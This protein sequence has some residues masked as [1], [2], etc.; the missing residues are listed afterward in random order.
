MAQQ[1]L[2][3]RTP[4]AYAGVENYA[5]QHPREVAG[6]LAWLVVGYAH[7]LDH[8][9]GK[10]IDALNRAK[11]GAEELGDY[12]AF[13]LADSY[14]QTAHGAEAVA[15]L[16]D[17]D[18]H[19]P[20]SLLARDAHAVYASALMKEG[21][22]QEA[23]AVLERERIP[24]RSDTELALGNAYQA[25]GQ[26]DK[27]VATFRN[28]FYN[29]P[30]SAEADI[31]GV[32]L[33]KL[34][35]NGTVAERR[36]RADLLLKARRY[37][38]AADEYRSLAS[39]V[40][41]VDQPG[42]NLALATALQR[43]DRSRDARQL[44]TSMGVQVGDAEAQRLFLLGEAERSTNDENAVLQTLVQLRQFGPSSPWL[45]QALLSA[46]N[47]Y[48]LK[49]DYDHAID[50][51]RELQQRFPKGARA[52]YAH[53][54]VSW[55]SLRQGRIEEA[56][57]GFEDQL[58]LYAES[59]EVPASLYWRARLAEEEGAAAMARAFYEK[60]SSRFRNYY[61]AELARQRLPQ[62]KGGAND[63]ATH[64]ALLD[65][66]PPLSLK[67]RVA[68]A[69]PPED[70]LRLQRARLLSNGALADLAA[71]E[72]QAAAK[73]DSRA[74]AIPEIARIY[75]D[76]GQFDRGIQVLKRAMPNYFAVD[77]PE[78]PRPYW[79]ALFPR[80]YWSD[81]RRF[82]V[83]NGLEPYLVASL[84]RQESEF[85]PLAVSRANA[86]GLMQ[87][88]PKTG[89]RVAREI[90]LKGYSPSQLYTPT[91]NLQLGTRYFKSMVDRYNGQLEYALAAYNAGTDRVDDW[92][93]AGKY[94][95]PQEFVESIPF[96][97]T[98]E[99]VQAILRNTNV[100]Q[101]LYGTP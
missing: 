31:A 16:A 25:V 97:E 10:A 46:G 96:T 65:R 40:P 77:L 89:K 70:D 2:L 61:Y 93:G 92:L 19:F 49:R 36:T 87:L 23:I 76:C 13:Y 26:A 20:D 91:V 47:M 11:S 45:E 8:D 68:S 50:H 44:L 81:L 35:V 4:A 98:R 41:T 95:D 83:Q 71:R 88:L 53:W 15:V 39:V 74:W 9:Y 3:D 34:K 6:S 12:V 29:F 99:Y 57:K 7:Y 55:L 82:S 37:S 67:D 58:A 80:P 59:N 48:L 32:E 62:L 64:Y 27:A 1:L 28:V 38:D 63:A 21:R 24:A 5:R 100:Y 54:K 66:I 86:V 75:Q 84:I 85:N 90:K 60:L 72:L 101:R 22:R 69:E 42:L 18:K 94:R 43:A 56:K 33:R 51:Y 17:F 14:L 79:D 52:S 30:V 78:L 73:D